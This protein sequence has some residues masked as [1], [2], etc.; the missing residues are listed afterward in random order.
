[1][2]IQKNPPPQMSFHWLRSL[3]NN[4]ASGIETYWEINEISKSTKVQKSKKLFQEGG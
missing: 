4:V 1:M 2:T 3:F